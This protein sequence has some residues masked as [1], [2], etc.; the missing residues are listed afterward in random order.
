MEYVIESYKMERKV[1]QQGKN[2]NIRP[3]ARKRLTKELKFL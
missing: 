1:K 2:K 3:V